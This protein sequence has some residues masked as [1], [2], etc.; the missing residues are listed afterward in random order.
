MS[1]APCTQDIPYDVK[2]LHPLCTSTLFFPTHELANP[3][4]MFI[5]SLPG[6]NAYI[7]K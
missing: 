1:S 4:A 6:K 3:M 7:S 5:H 2:A